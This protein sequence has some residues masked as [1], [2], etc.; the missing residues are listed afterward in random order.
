MGCPVSIMGPSATLPRAISRERS[1]QRSQV[2]RNNGRHLHA[3]SIKC[4]RDGEGASGGVGMQGHSTI[5][6]CACTTHTHP[7]CKFQNRA[8]GPSLN[9]ARNTRGGVGDLG[10]RRGGG[11]GVSPYRRGDHLHLGLPEVPRTLLYALPHPLF[12]RFTTPPIPTHPKN[13]SFMQ[14]TP[15]SIN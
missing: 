2:R 11:W 1:P 3:R 6:C 15:N 13:A 14:N 7:M 10:K 5:G 9:S 12:I 4:R 8:T